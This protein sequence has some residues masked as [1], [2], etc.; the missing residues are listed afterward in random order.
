MYLRTFL[1]AS[2]LAGT[3]I[4]AGVFSLPFVFNE[5]GMGTGLFYMAFLTIFFTFIHLLYADMAIRTPGEH[6]FVSYSQM[7]LGNMGFWLAIFMGLIQLL[8]V[9]AIYLILSPSFSGLFID[10][11]T[12]YQLLVFWIVGSLGVLLNI[13]RVAFIE[14]LITVGIIFIILL[15][16]FFGIQDISLK[17]IN[18]NF[19]LYN[20]MTVGPILFSLS[21]IVAIP[22]M[23]SYFRA[24][25][26]PLSLLK[27]SIYW[28]IGASVILYIL[29]ILGIFGL[30][31]TISG[32]AVSTLIESTPTG[33]VI[34]IGILGILSLLSSYIVVGLDVRRVLQYDLLFSSTFSKLVVIFVPILLYLLGVKNF[35][36]S[37]D[38]VGRVFLPLEAI[39]VIFIWRNAN[40]KLEMPP[41]LLNKKTADS[42]I[43]I[44]ILLFLIILFYGMLL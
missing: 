7:Y 18:W 16:F 41:L 30:S 40:K 11:N 21:G 3:L 27:K 19:N 42:M 24:S 1:P 17:D 26:T 20:F 29:F 13:E 32:D 6:R 25:R 14:F 4:G 9:L 44:T 36:N 12:F 8:I 38:F 15:T 39:F 5:S 28:G 43:P 10:N 37:V 22:E 31:S 23:I 35:V 33:V 34:A 2:I